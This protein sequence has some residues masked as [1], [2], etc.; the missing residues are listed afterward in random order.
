MRLKLVPCLGALCALQLPAPSVAQVPP[1]DFVVE[2]PFPTATFDLPVEIAF[3]PDGRK[4]VCE[5]AGMVWVV[6]ANGTKSFPPF[7]DIRPEVALYSDLGMLGMA[8]DPDFATNR[9]VYLAYA[10]DPNGDGVEDD[11]ER[12]ARLTRYQASVGNPNVAD[13]ASRQVLIGATW[14]QGMVVTHT[15]HTVGAIRF[16]ADKSLLLSVGEGA[17]FEEVDDGNLDFNAFTPG[18]T[19]PEEDIGAFRAQTL[20]SL[21][22]KVLRVDKETG[23]G[24]ASNPYWN[25]DGTAKRSKV[26]L[27]GL[28]NPFRFCVRPGTGSTNIADGDPGTLYIGDVGRDTWEELSVAQVGG[29]NFGWPCIEGPANSDDYQAVTMVHTGNPNVL[30]SAAPSAE[31]PAAKTGPKLWWHHADSTSSNPNGWTGETAV[32]GCF[33]TGTSYPPAWQGRYYVADWTDGWIRAV[34]VDANDDVLGWADFVT[35]ALGPVTVQ[36]EPA[37]GNLHFI[38]LFTNEILRVRYTGAVSVTPGGAARLDLAVRA[39]PNPFHATTTIEFDLPSDANVTLAVYDV[40]G[41]MV[42]RLSRGNLPAGRHTVAWDGR[43]ETGARRIS[44]VYFA[45]LTAGGRNVALKLV[46]LD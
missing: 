8:V 33:Y 24:L 1:P 14:T 11:E 18:K 21:C 35:N 32:G 42:R 46:P 45:Q 23:L 15:T 30:C 31:N 5:D 13:L 6:L 44:G 20:N 25:G 12:F 41:R 16:G 39:Q 4:L 29:L 9:W 38:S 17:H 26:W 27:Y 36:A 7:L 43:D 10:V 2:N 3:L 34:E 22:G 28:R 37:T 19:D 40:G